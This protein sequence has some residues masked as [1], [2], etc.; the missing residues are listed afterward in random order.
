MTYLKLKND[1]RVISVVTDRSKGSHTDQK[2]PGQHL[3]LRKVLMRGSKC[4]T[5]KLSSYCPWL[6]RYKVGHRISLAQFLDHN[7]KI[8]GSVC[9]SNL[10][11]T[12]IWLGF[13]Q[14]FRKCLFNLSN[15][16]NT[17]GWLRGKGNSDFKHQAA[18]RIWLKT[19]NLLL[20]FNPVR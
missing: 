7:N 9:C 15:K 4:C 17:F 20:Q 6:E 18:S 1:K 12:S 13:F 10:D 8:D 19:W 2:V 14:F 16:S 5:K 11:T 3:I